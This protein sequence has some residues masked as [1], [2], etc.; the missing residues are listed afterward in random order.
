MATSRISRGDMELAARLGEALPPGAALDVDG[1]PTVDAAAGLK[2]TQLPFGGHKGAALALAVELLG[3]ALLGTD[4]A[5]D[6]ESSAAGM[7]RGV[8]FLAIDPSRLS[9]TAL[10]QA[11]RLFSAMQRDEGVRLPAD[12][13]YRARAAAAEHGVQVDAVLAEECFGA[14]FVRA[15]AGPVVPVGLV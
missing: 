8:F 12:S 3:S 15:D 2:G 7:N 4:L 10:A 9:Q 13:R 5:I 14:D 1:M 6:A 11:E